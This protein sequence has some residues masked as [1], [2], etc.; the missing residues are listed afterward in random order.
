MGDTEAAEAS[1]RRSLGLDP[2]NVVALQGL[3]DV[4]LAK[5]K[6]DEAR[7]AAEQSIAR[8]PDFARG[9]YNQGRAG[10]A[11]AE[12]IARRDASDARVRTLLAGLR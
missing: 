3:F 12:H 9:Y 4:C 2:T 10:F 7:A 8:A 11:E 6:F 5:G 1:F